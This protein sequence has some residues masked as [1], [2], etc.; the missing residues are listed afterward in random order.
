MSPRLA[1]LV[2]PHCNCM[3]PNLC[4]S[5]KAGDAVYANY[6][7]DAD[8]AHLLAWYGFTLPSTAADSALLIY[9]PDLSNSVVA[10]RVAMLHDAGICGVDGALVQR[11]RASKPLWPQLANTLA[12]VRIVL[13]PSA[14]PACVPMR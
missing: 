5:Y 10:E 12:F 7:G 9:T 4:R 11:V 3:L 1:R 8:N 2:E 6:G 14:T 13:S